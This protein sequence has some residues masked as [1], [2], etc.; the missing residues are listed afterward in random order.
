MSQ[1][2]V[3]VY[4]GRYVKWGIE[5][6][7]TGLAATLKLLGYDVVLTQFDAK[8][9]R[10]PIDQYRDNDIVIMVYNQTMTTMASK[11]YR[12]PIGKLVLYNFEPTCVNNV[13]DY[14]RRWY[15][16]K[17]VRSI[18]AY[19]VKPDLVLDFC[20][21]GDIWHDKVGIKSVWLPLG[22]SEA[23][24]IRNTSAKPKYD[25]SF[26]GKIR[27]SKRRESI[28]NGALKNMPINYMKVAM[29]YDHNLIYKKIAIMMNAPIWLNIHR[30]GTI[31]D[32]ADIRVIAYGMCNKCCVVTEESVWSPPFVDGIHWVK[33]DKDD[34]MR[35]DINRLLADNEKR[36]RIG[37]NGYSF[38]KKH[39]NYA[40]HVERVISDI[41]E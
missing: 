21:G 22:Y 18:E 29:H 40:I 15:E 5:F 9:E 26:L 19:G 2:F 36:N 32:F 28:V 37:E 7:A 1:R 16:D 33:V 8:G 11:N 13:D 38:V 17:Y 31:K 23:F 12:P 39:W 25:I 35:D 10:F 24:E 41:L 27:T 6:V 30:Q 20:P 3:V 34:G 14:I 4:S